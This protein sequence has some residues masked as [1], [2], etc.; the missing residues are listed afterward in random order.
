MITKRKWILPWMALFCCLLMSLHA[1]AYNKLSIPDVF[2]TQG[3]IIDVPVNLENDDQVVALQFTLTVPNGVTIDVNSSRLTNRAPDHSIHIVKKQG[4][5]YLCLVFSN[6]NTAFIGN[7]GAVM[8]LAISL[9]NQ[10]S[11]GDT[12]LLTIRDAVA[13]D[14]AMN[15]VLTESS[16]GSIIVGSNITESPTITYSITDDAAVI[17]AEGNGEVKLYKDGVQVDNPCIVQRTNVDQV[18]TFTAT[19]Q[20]DG[21]EISVPAELVLII[22]AAELKDL[23]GMIIISNP[24]ENGVVTITYT[25]VEDVTIT[26]FI[27]GEL[28]EGDIQLQEGENFI[29][30]I[31]EAPGY[32]SIKRTFIISWTPPLPHE[33]AYYLVGMAPFGTGWDPSS[34]IRMTQNTDG[35]YSYSAIIDGTIYFVLADNLAADSWDWETFNYNY[36]IGPD[37]E[38]DET[39]TAGVWTQTQRANGSSGAYK[40]TGTGSEYTITFN[41][42]VMRFKI[43]GD[44][45]PPPVDTYTVAGSPAAV[46]GTEWD[47]TNTDNDMI[48]QGDGTYRLVKTNCRLFGGS[49]IEFKVAANHDWGENWP[50]SNY[51][52]NV[53]ESGIYS[54]T[55][56]FNPTNHQIDCELNKQGSIPDEDLPNLHLVSLNCSD[57]VAGHQMTVQWKVRNDGAAETGNAQWKDYIWLVPSISEGSSMIGSKLLKTV[58]NL[59]AL[60]PGES[61]T[62]TV[63]VQLEERVYGNYDLLVTSDMYGVSNIDF[64]QTGGAPPIPYEPETSEYGFLMGYANRSFDLLK[65]TGESDGYSDNFFYKR[66]NIVVPPLPD[67]QVNSVVAVVDNTSSYAGETDGP[68]P[69][70]NAGLASSTMFYSGKKV[71]V[72][73]N[74]KNGGAN[75]QSTYITNLLYLSTSPDLTEGQAILLDAHGMTINLNSGAQTQ[76]EFSGTIPYEWSGESYFVVI[77][78]VEDA[79]YESANTGNNMAASPSVNVLL[80][81]GADFQPQT[82]N[83]P[84]QI[85]PAPFDVTYTVKNIGPGVPY[86]NKWKDKIYVSE[87]ATGIDDTAVEL[88]SGEQKGRYVYVGPSRAV[89]VSY[90][91]YEYEGDNY[92]NTITI[93]GTKIKG[94]TSNDLYLY[95]VVD[96][97]DDV[98]EYD[99][100]N[101]NVIMSQKISLVKTDLT[102]ELI[103]ISEDTLVSGN[104]VAFSWLVKNNGSVGLTN[105]RIK[106]RIY[107]QVDNSSQQIVFKDIDNTIS[108]VPGGEKILHANV[109]IPRR[110]SLSGNMNVYVK[111]NADNDLDETDFS[112]NTSVPLSRYV[113]LVWDPSPEDIWASGFNLTG[114]NLHA[115]QEAVPGQQIALSYTIKNTG[116]Y[117]F[118]SNVNQ[119]I[120]ISKNSSFSLESSKKCEVSSPFPNVS[121][122]APR[123]TVAAN[124]TV[125]IPDDMQGGNNYLHVVINRE[126]TLQES[127]RDDNIIS[128]PIFINGNMP[129]LAVTDIQVPDVIMTSVPTQVSWTVTNVGDWNAAATTCGIYLSRDAYHSSDDILLNNVPVSSLTKS[130]SVR[131]NTNITLN[132]DVIGTRYIIIKADVDRKLTESNLNNNTAAA[133]FTSKQSPLPDLVISDLTCD[134]EWPNGG[135]VNIKANV[136][137]VGDSKTRKD[138]WAD[139]FYLSDGPTFDPDQAI[140]LGSK[141]HVGH[142]APGESYVINAEFNLPV[143]LSGDYELIAITDG[144]QA[145]IEKDENNNS[146]SKAV[147]VQSK[148]DTPADLVVKNVSAPAK[149]NAGQM[150]VMSY[151]IANNGE[152]PASGVIR[153]LLY[154]SKDETWD[155]SDIM[156]GTAYDELTVNP[157]EEKTRWVAGRITGVPEG[158][159]HLIVRTN[160]TRRVAE[161]DYTNNIG[162]QSSLCSVEFPRLVLD[163]TVTANG[164]GLYKMPLTSD[165][166]GKT[167]GIFMTYTDDAFAGLY[168]SYEQVPTSATYD[169]SSHNLEEDH[170]EIL[171]SDVQ[172]GTYYVMAQGSSTTPTSPGGNNPAI[173]VNPGG[174]CQFI[175]VLDASFIP[176]EPQGTAMTITAREVPFGATTLSV[177]EGGVD[178]W[179]STNVRGALFDSIMDFRLEKGLIRLPAESI[180]FH[181]QTS[182]HATFNLHDMETGS[183]DFISEL[184][185]GAWASLPDGF[186][187]VPANSVNL[188][189]KLDAPSATAIHG[190]APV[191]ISYVNSG[192]N[193]III[194]ELLLTIDGGELGYSIEDIK[195]DPKQVLHIRPDVNLDNRGFLV[196]PPGREQTFNY[197]FKQT[198]GWTHL[199]LYIVK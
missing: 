80:T 62:N 182:S 41:P 108:L 24:D 77:A 60:A 112:N 171:I 128:A 27:N 31:V 173:Y 59:S 14:A 160:T 57:P 172:E 94:F 144:N 97:D 111:T 23:T 134:D 149:I 138:K 2:V 101:N 19:A 74:I 143:D 194:R 26:V 135:V 170:Q 88:W 98:Y 178:G 183:Y 70:S 78:D 181:D 66:I 83:V 169:Y 55:I 92:T 116:E 155:E 151:V 127:R 18:C 33:T 73:A 50:S 12:Y 196:I 185:S 4:N 199:Y 54:I 120:F 161:T 189:V 179:I 110:Q 176:A 6:S 48:Q 84:T 7:S 20:E 1:N 119:E 192:N 93:D 195:K 11:E 162:V 45:V 186:R 76:V 34:G 43:D 175:V 87:K 159:Y 167:I 115:P 51:L 36:R 122:L 180:T 81:P 129:D 86:V 9:P 190:Y 157:G 10:V 47:V 174:V 107:A 37:V 125:T 104:T 17:T 100:E 96:A 90:T 168:S 105:A 13:S 16:A 150:M 187:I 69:I 184:P 124:L 25:G 82:L 22:P 39:V 52:V 154:L 46:F 188:G 30:V 103:S 191:S 3:G 146:T 131:L 123:Q 68:S 75:I 35:T 177:R 130:S 158:N 29:Y 118:G 65:E 38:Q 106:D 193:D 28:I 137:N 89:V 133:A 64:S 79:V 156:V 140:R 197:Y 72:T 8:N 147:Y 148:S 71:K 42:E 136:R 67:L 63:D 102:V 153:D 164:F 44:V 163:E 139:V 85:S 117:V 142:M 49:Q 15:N 152:Y 141:A 53:E 109:T 32:N 99:G 5:D 126:N 95:L 21:K 91:I 145:I 132:D 56:T 198:S 114:Y 113:K 61:Y 165:L 166:E 40:F 121:G 58:D